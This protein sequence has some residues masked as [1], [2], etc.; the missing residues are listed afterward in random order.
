MTYDQAVASIDDPFDQ[1]YVWSG[2]RC[3]PAALFMDLMAVN[4]Q[5][6]E[7]VWTTAT[8]QGIEEYLDQLQWHLTCNNLYSDGFV[9]VGEYWHAGTMRELRSW[10]AAQFDK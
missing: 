10:V 8:K 7:Y 9:P 4:T 6:G 5:T 2:G 3:A 1:Q